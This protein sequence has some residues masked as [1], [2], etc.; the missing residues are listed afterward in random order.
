[1]ISYDKHG[2][3]LGAA[4]GQLIPGGTVWNEH[5][6]HHQD[7]SLRHSRVGTVAFKEFEHTFQRQGAERV[8]IECDNPYALSDES[9]AHDLSN[10]A[11]RRE[12]W[13]GEG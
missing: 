11:Q 6:W 5:T 2:N 4:S 8:M 3:V 12:F 1:M 10:P 9:T 13:K 7:D